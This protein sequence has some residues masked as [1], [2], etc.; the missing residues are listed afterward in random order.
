M[1]VGICISLPAIQDFKKYHANFSQD[2][3]RG[4][5]SV[6][7]LQESKHVGSLLLMGNMLTKKYP[8]FL[9][10]DSL[11]VDDILEWDYWPGFMQIYGMFLSEPAR[12]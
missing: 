5:Q 7:K 9:I 2:S 6:E 12:V 4:A 8:K 11:S 1:P 3:A 10:E